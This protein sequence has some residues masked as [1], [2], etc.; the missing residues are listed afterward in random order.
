VTEIY[1]YW[2]V[3]NSKLLGGKPKSQR[4]KC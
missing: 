3:M 2:Q 4:S 1:G